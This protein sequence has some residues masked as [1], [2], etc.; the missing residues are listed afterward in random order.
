MNIE[1]DRADIQ[2]LF[3]R[4]PEK[5]WQP[6]EICTALEFRGKQIKKLQGTLRRM[7]VDGEIVELRPGIFGLGKPADLVTGKMRMIRSGA[8][9]VLDNAT[10][11][12]K[13]ELV[14]SFAWIAALVAGASNLIPFYLISRG[15][16]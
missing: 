7:V 11:R 16:P 4:D 8:G 2:A 3:A 10:A 6:K 12:L 14:L 15:T 9:L 5:T 13:W 1:K